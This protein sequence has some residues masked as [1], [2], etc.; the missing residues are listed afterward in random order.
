MPATPAG[1]GARPVVRSGP[2]VGK[3]TA[4]SVVA[5]TA[6]QPLVLAGCGVGWSFGWISPYGVEQLG[7]Q[8]GVGPRDGVPDRVG[9]PVDGGGG[10]VGAQKPRRLDG[11][12]VRLRDGD[13]VVVE[14]V[15]K[16]LGRAAQ[17]VGAR[18]QVGLHLCGLGQP[19]GHPELGVLDGLVVVGGD[20]VGRRGSQLH[21][22]PW[23]DAAQSPRA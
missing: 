5:A 23:V 14:Q 21:G 3:A 10:R 15:G 20:R 12:R 6:T 2:P 7:A 13:L 4:S 9:Q 19:G 17:G 8:V 18:P 22:L 1:A 11:V 16:D